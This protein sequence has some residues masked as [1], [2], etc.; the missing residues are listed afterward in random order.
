M[1]S[2]KQRTFWFNNYSKVSL[3]LLYI[4]SNNAGEKIITK[5]FNILDSEPVYME[6]KLSRVQFVRRLPQ[7]PWARQLFSCFFAKPVKPFLSETQTWLGWRSL[8]FKGRVT[9]LPAGK[10]FVIYTL[11]LVCQGQLDQV[12][13]Y[14]AACARV[15]NGKENGAKIKVWL[16]LTKLC[17]TLPW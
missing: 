1:R 10:L 5:T 11:W 2:N 17:C 15:V 16:E 4:P 6:E 14:R 13:I 3:L 9:F 8:T 12:W 7:L